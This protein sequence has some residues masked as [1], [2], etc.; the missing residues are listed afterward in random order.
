MEYHPLSTGFENGLSQNTRTGK[1]LWTEVVFLLSRK[2]F[3]YRKF[4]IF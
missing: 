3:S 4:V 1:S 2:L